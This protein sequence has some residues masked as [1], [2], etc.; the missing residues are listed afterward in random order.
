MRLAV[1]RL[2]EAIRA[3]AAQQ[4]RKSQYGYFTNLF[5][6]ELEMSQDQNALLA[7]VE[8]TDESVDTVFL[9]LCTMLESR[10][11]FRLS[12]S[13]SETLAAFFDHMADWER[14][15]AGSKHRCRFLKRS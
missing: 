5:H 12:E 3:I 2:E 11:A 7:A 14:N 4:T 15:R 1:H 8:A 13:S 10:W 6:D 9:E